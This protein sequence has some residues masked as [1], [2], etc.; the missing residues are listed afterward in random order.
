MCLIGGFLTLELDSFGVS[1]FG[2]RKVLFFLGEAPLVTEA[3]HRFSTWA[4]FPYGNHITMIFL[5]GQWNMYF[6]FSSMSGPSRNPKSCK[7]YMCSIHVLTCYTRGLQTVIHRSSMG[8][9]SGSLAQSQLH[10]A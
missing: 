6:L 8:I 3:A 7:I 5:I 4:G 2:V 9:Q 1:D 10:W